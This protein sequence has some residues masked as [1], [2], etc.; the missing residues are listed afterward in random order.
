MSEED[1]DAGWRLACLTHVKGEYRLEIEDSRED[2]I[3]G[4]ADGW[5]AG[6]DAWALAVDLGTTTI[7]ASLVSLS[8][9]KVIRTV[10]GINHQRAFGTDVLARID[11]ANR[12]EGKKLQQLIHNDASSLCRRLGAGRDI[13]RIS[14]PV[15][16]AGNTTMQHL[17]QGLPC[18]TLGVYPY[19]PVD[20]SMHSYGNEGKITVL[21]GISTYVG[22]DIVSG[23]VACGMDQKEE[24]S[25]LA[26]LG[27]NAEMVIGNKDRILA[28]SAAA[29]PAF[30]GGN[31]RWGVAS[32]PGAIDTVRI[33]DGRAE[34]TT[35]EG[36]DPIGICGTG[37]LESVYELVKAG[38]TDETGLLDEKYFDDGYPLA[39][40]ITL[41]AKDIREVQMA[42]AAIRAGIE[43]LI[44]AYGT[45]YEQID[46]LYLAGGF[47]QKLDC[48]KAVGIG[49]LPEELK[50]KAFAVG[51]ASLA[52]A[53][54]AAADPSQKERFLHVTQ[55]SKEILLANHKH[56]SDL[57]IKY[58]F[59]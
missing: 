35:I 11:A 23:I 12:G 30:E 8:D 33:V 43:I 39:P 16:L 50:D 42:K 29:G 2:S 19:E 10:T 36:K 7:A 27:T 58:M 18:R 37:V 25:I 51:N 5:E 26:D 22:A 34:I 59:F 41:T 56:F 31:I 1:L 3:A 57:Y 17:F 13:N 15:A 4:P 54:A 14:A 40:G 24:I 53:V 48:A 44:S 55:N 38:I 20:I 46:R 47:G 6:D 52:G 28:A 49:L 45:T 21:P 9:K 32:V